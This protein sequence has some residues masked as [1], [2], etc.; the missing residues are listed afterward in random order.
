MFD[1][2]SYP[3]IP[4]KSSS[5]PRDFAPAARVLPFLIGYHGKQVE[6]GCSP[7][8]SKWQYKFLAN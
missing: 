4:T 2:E 1:E 7:Y 5:V 3:N 6:A 8:S